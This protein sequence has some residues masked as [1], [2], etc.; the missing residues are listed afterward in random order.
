MREILKKNSHLLGLLLISGAAALTLGGYLLLSG[1]P[2]GLGFPLDDAWIHQ[3]YARNLALRG[4]W[5][6][7][8]G[9]PS[10]G[11]TSPLWTVLL[12][13]GYFLRLPPLLWTF[14]LGW[15][16][17]TGVAWLGEQFFRQITGAP[18]GA[19]PWVGLF[20]VGEWH[21]VWAAGAGMETC[22]YAGVVLAVFWLLARRLLAPFLCGLV[23]GAAVWVRPDGLTLLGPVLFVMFLASAGWKV[24]FRGLTGA[25]SGFLVL[26]L[27]YLVFNRILGGA[28]WPNTYYA[29]QAEYV[30]LQQLPLL[31]RL[32]QQAELP[33]VGAGIALMPGFVVAVWAAL[34]SRQW[35]VLAGVL[36][37]AGYT[38]LY[39]VALPVGY[40]HGRY[41]IPA[42][43]VFFIIG[44]IGTLRLVGRSNPARWLRLARF[45]CAA[46]I[47]LIWGVFLIQGALAYR[48]DVAIIQT[49][50][51]PAARWIARNT[52][53]DALIAAHDIGALGYYGERRILDLAGLIS[54]EVIPFIRDETRLAAYLDERSAAYLVSFPGWYPLLTQR[55][56]IQFVTSGTISP[57]AGGEN[58]TIYRWVKP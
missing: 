23:C 53:P 22:L 27:P 35:V 11:S 52:P 26:F 4:E 58:M 42:M 55:A 45:A 17:L 29:K 31:Q 16:A 40:Q 50:M 7:L 21:L 12:A 25:I 51:V 20:L 9:L 39:A 14:G 15:V 10:A 13:L 5:A 24:R 19:L 38:F 57:G 3:T 18:G 44:L 36:W 41:L 54:P 34:K 2:A 37:W 8:P 48:E 46:L 32:A 6:F 28:W 47:G 1:G 43:P 30:L 33:L 49:E 56:Q